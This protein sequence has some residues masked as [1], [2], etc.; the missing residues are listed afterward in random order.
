LLNH[1]QQHSRDDD[2][3]RAVGAWDLTGIKPGDGHVGA[4][5]APCACAVNRANSDVA[6]QQAAVRPD[7]V[8]HSVAHFSAATGELYH[9]S[10]GQGAYG[11]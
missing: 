1:H 3:D 11:L 2:F 8:G 4:L 7:S 10:V 5:R 6:G 9:R